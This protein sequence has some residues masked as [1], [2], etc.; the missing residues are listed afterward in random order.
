MRVVMKP[1]FDAELPPG[2]EEILK[3]KLMGRELRTGEEVEVELLGKPLPFK[4]LL[5]EPSPLK[6]GRGTKIELSR[7]DVEVLDF[8]F[9]EAVKEV[10]PFDGGF[11][12]V[13]GRK[14][15]ILNHT[16]QKIYSDEFE[17]LNGVRVSKGTVV[18]IHDGNK[19][20]LVK[21]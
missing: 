16:G 14:V 9:D 21:P 19:I 8:E 15:L 1:L 11:V 2:F 18:I 10:V 4:V 7:G 5:A 13:L 3:D 20:R 12:V 6:V 17:E